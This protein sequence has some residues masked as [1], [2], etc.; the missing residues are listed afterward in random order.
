M[1]RTLVQINIFFYHMCGSVSGQDEPNPV[2][3]LATRAG[4]MERSCLLGITRFVPQEKFH[5]FGVLSHIINP[6]LTKLVRS[7][8]LDIGLVLFLRVYSSRSINTQKKNLANIQPSWPLAWSIIIIITHTYIFYKSGRRPGPKL[9]AGMYKH[10]ALFGKHAIRT[11]NILALLSLIIK[12]FFRFLNQTGHFIVKSSLWN[13][14]NSIFP[15]SDL[16][17]RAQAHHYLCGHANKVHCCCGCVWGR[18]MNAR[19]AIWSHTFSVSCYGWPRIDS[20]VRVKCS[21]N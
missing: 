16:A 19:Y 21:I 8:W 4:K 18:V 9:N 3:W 6:L 2:L 7:R 14:G 13:S 10:H 20:T 11:T 5:F 1:F 12:V 15:Y 17:E